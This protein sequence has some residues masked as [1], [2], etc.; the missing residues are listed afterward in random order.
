[1]M[2]VDLLCCV[3]YP[4]LNVFVVVVDSGILFYFFYTQNK[5]NEILETHVD[6]SIFLLCELKYWYGVC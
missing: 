4:V 5:M 3:S 6:I 2:L 1:M